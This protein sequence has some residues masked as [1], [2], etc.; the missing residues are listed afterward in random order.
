[1]LE[2]IRLML[3]EKYIDTLPQSTINKLKKSMYRAVDLIEMFFPDPM[4]FSKT[5]KLDQYQKD[6]IDTI[7]FG[8]PL[9][10]FKFN[11]VLNPPKGVIT[12]WARQRGK[13]WSCAYSCSAL[14]ILGPYSTGKPP[15]FNGIIAASEDESQMLIDKVKTCFYE[16][17]FND[18]VI[19]KPRADKIKLI[20]GSYTKSHTCSHTSIRGAFYHYCIIDESAQMD[21]SILFSAAIPTTTHGER[22]VAITTPLGSKGKLMNYYIKA[23]KSRP[24]ICV[25]CGK[26]YDQ[27]HFPDANFP[28]KNQIWKMPKLPACENCGGEIYKYGMGIWATPWMNPWKCSLID[29]EELKRILDSHAWSPWARQEFLGEVI[30]EASMVILDEW[31]RKNTVPSLRNVMKKEFGAE[32]ILGVDYGRLHDAS[33]FAV[34]H[35]NKKT[36]RIRLDYLKA[37]SGEYDFETDYDGIRDVLLDIIEFYRPAIIVPDSTGLGYAQVERLKK[38]LQSLRIYSKIYTNY[39]GTKDKPRLGFTINKQSKTELIGNLITMMSAEP[40][41]LEI[42]PRTEPE[43]YELVTEM[44]RFE[45]EVMEGGYIKYGT[46]NYHDDRLIALA[47]SLMGHTG[48][49]V[50]ISK[51]RAFDYDV[52]D[53][54]K[55]RG[56]GRK[57]YKPTFVEVF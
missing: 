12:V 9:S 15:C 5:V 36:G 40:P 16:S 4:D 3:D 42:P 2:G 29:N 20:N 31:I 26:H 52:F 47:L 56:F 1:M 30:D 27:K 21:E 24:I 17:D 6:F 38:D 22:W 55:K 53:E 45:C 23:V 34:T 25:S 8:F 50:P 35:L 39:K 7:Q 49:K 19:G 28:E 46:Q 10:Q 48:R 51:P 37:V 41:R 54:K 32:Y 11:E 13:S 18:F 14:M 33:A 57:R 43:I 44:L